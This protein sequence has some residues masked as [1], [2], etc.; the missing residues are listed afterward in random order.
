MS[1][2]HLSLRPDVHVRSTPDGECELVLPATVRQ[3]GKLEPALARAVQ[4][5]DGAAVDIAELEDEL[6]QGSDPAEAAARVA[7]LS[8]LI[9]VLSPV[10][11]R[12][13]VVSGERLL[14][15][16]QM[17]GPAT[18]EPAQL[19]G[20]AWVRASR[21][22][23]TRADNGQTI[24][25]SPLS[26]WRVAVTDSRVA[27][28]VADLAEPRRLE[29]VTT[30]TGA[31]SPGQRNAVFEALAAYDLIAVDTNNPAEPPSFAEDTGVVAQWSH[32]DMLLHARSR[33]GRHD[34]PY[35]GTF[36]YLGITPPPQAV[37][38]ER[39]GRVVALYRPLDIGIGAAEPSFSEVLEAR[40]SFRSYG[41]EGP[42]IDQL[43][44]FLFRAARTRASYGPVPERGMPYEAADR[45]YPSGGGMH[46]LEIYV[47]P[48]RVR[49]LDPAVYY[50]DSW[51]HQL[52]EVN[53]DEKVINL[54]LA[55]A[56]ISKSGGQ[57]PDVLLTITSRFER[58]SWKYEQ[59][60]YATTLRNVGVLYQTLY[61][62]ATAMGLAPCALGGGDSELVATAIG[63]DP[64]T[65]GSVG[66]FALGSMPAPAELEAERELTVTNNV[67]WRPGQAPYWCQVR[68]HVISGYRRE[69]V[70]SQSG[71]LRDHNS[72]GICSDGL[73]V[74]ARRS[75][76]P[77]I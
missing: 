34:Y 10:L 49:G 60:A 16:T 62:V 33:I 54:L 11:S 32:V 42:D 35:G 36:R 56:T 64:F 52:V 53:N 76:A 15:A 39:G 55:T 75:M 46:D 38:A 68:S 47:T 45:P 4:R 61:L 9:Q 25:E 50:Y 6:L 70:P 71:E 23:V 57:R 14:V 26:F 65:E 66:D 7:R 13:L 17:T 22:A 12:H 31:L 48:G 5:F 18:H 27:G 21:F 58:L 67:T 72:T 73:T 37:R 2:L 20:H 63:T 59:I 69:P 28:L 24:L 30:G 29:A 8:K 43:G 44:E 74:F 51:R 40:Q 41:P 1:A 19:P 77:E 3:F